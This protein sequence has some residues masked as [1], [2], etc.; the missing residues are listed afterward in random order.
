[1][2]RHRPGPPPRPFHAPLPGVRMRPWHLPRPVRIRQALAFAGL[3]ALTLGLVLMVAAPRSAAQI[4]RPGRPQVTQPNAPHAGSG[5]GTTVTGPKMWDPLHDKPFPTA[6]TVTVAQ[7]TS[8]ADQLVQVSW[9]GFTPSVPNN[10]AGPYYVYNYT[11]YAVMAVECRGASPASWTDCYEATSN[12]VPQASGT[13][14]PPNATYAITTTAGTGQLNIEIETSL[15][16]SFLGCGQSNPCSLVIVPGQGGTPVPPPGGK[17]ENCKDHSG[18]VA[19]GGGGNALAATTF[20]FGVGGS[21][22]CSWNNRIVIPLQFAPVPTGCKQRNAAFTVAGSP[23]MAVAMQ[24]WLTKLCAGNNGMTIAYNSTIAEPQAVQ[25]AAG[26]VQNVALTTRPAS[27]DGV[28]TTQHFVYAPIAVSAV[29]VAYWIDNTNNG[30]PMSGLILNQRLLAKLLTTSYNPALACHNGLPAG[31][32]NGVDHNP[33]SIFKDP[34]FKTLDSSIYNNVGIGAQ[35][36]EVPTVQSGN[37]DMTWTVTSWINANSDASGFLAGIFDPWGTHVNSYYVGVK[38]PTD[39]FTAQDPTLTW[40]QEFSPVFP[41]RQ[42]VTYQALNEN[43]GSDQPTVNPNGQIIY[44]KDPP[45]PIGDRALFAVVDMGDAALNHFPVAALPNADGKDVTPSNAS[46]AAAVSRMSNSGSGTLQMNLTDKTPAAYPLTMVIYAM[47]PT[48]GLSHAKAAAIARFL[49]FAAGS[50]QTPGLQPGQLPPGYMPLPAKLRAETRKLAAE[51]AKQK[52]NTSPGATPSPGSSLPAS[53]ANPKP[54]PSLALPGVSPS[55]SGTGAQPVSLLA[56][57]PRSAA[58]TRYILPALLV[59]GGLAALAGSSAL[60]GSEGGIAGRLR[61]MGRSAA[62][63][64]RKAWTS[65]VRGRRRPASG[66]PGHTGPPHPGPGRPSR[67][68]RWRRK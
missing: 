24:Q 26:G 6:S 41:L 5:S 1:M 68:S 17:P 43:A 62:A 33:F 28:T 45:E 53:T 18:D 27:A 31:C 22:P 35:N 4:T 32:D 29:A 13:S 8:L 7:T 44:T 21:G 57:H 64:P 10:A 15:E 23:M 58:I 34:E 46:M 38:Y 63:F 19:F 52:E 47:V 49:D 2:R 51:V 59:L 11:D 48:S 16:N 56:A 55:S 9:T 20:N 12:G 60:A 3:V 36:Y 39:T 37:S 42:A 65:A 50:G 30:Q 40:A 14:G 67:P 66:A 61:L 25:Q 54:S